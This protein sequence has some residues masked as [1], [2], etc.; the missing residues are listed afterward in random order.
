[1]KKN[2]VQVALRVDREF[3][4]ALKEQAKINHR[5]L[6]AHL[7]FLV[8]SAFQRTPQGK[9]KVASAKSASLSRRSRQAACGN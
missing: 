4:A 8:E 1:M 2:T 9:A 5:S 6:H 3:H 7:L